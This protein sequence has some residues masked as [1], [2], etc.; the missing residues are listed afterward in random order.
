MTGSIVL[1]PGA[2]S[3]VVSFPVAFIGK[4]DKNVFEGWSDRPDVG[5]GDI[6]FA[7]GGDDGVFRHIIVD[8]DLQ[9]LTEYRRHADA[10][11]VVHGLE[12]DGDVVAGDI[13]AP[14]I[15]RVDDR[16]VFKVIVLSAVAETGK[17]N[18]A[19]VGTALGL[20]PV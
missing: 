1:K 17:I 11:Q 14:G 4:G 16:Q 19:D 7:K 9:R 13:N 6:H 3:L 5:A 8:E 20:I 2:W 10:G 15:G 18:V 12:A